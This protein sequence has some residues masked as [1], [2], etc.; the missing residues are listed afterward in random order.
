VRGA[1]GASDAPGHVGR[2]RPRDAAPTAAAGEVV[3]PVRLGKARGQCGK[4]QAGEVHGR[5]DVVLARQGRE[6]LA[7]LARF[8]ENL[9]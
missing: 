1:A 6:A 4:Q 2:A 9:L 5:S 3:D 7:L 8:G